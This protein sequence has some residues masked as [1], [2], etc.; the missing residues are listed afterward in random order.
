MIYKVHG[1]LKSLGLPLDHNFRPDFDSK[2]MVISYHFFNEGGLKFGDGKI[3]SFGGALQ[4]DLFVKHSVNFIDVKKNIVRLLTNDCFIL[5]NIDT[6][7]EVVD[8]IGK[9]DHIIFK[10]NYMERNDT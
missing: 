6:T 8:G 3:T 9:I 5:E 2:E 1:I 7:T 10:F 4:I